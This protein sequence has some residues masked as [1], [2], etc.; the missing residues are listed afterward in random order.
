[1][2]PA[3]CQKGFKDAKELMDEKN[4]EIYNEKIDHTLMP[5]IKRQEIDIEA[6]LS[7]EETVKH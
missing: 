2:N 7:Q 3:F 5:P 6:A 1:M 4:G